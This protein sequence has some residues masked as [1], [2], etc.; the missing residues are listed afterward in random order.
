M[1]KQQKGAGPSMY[2]M[3][4][5]PYRNKAW[6]TLLVLSGILLTL[7]VAYYGKSLGLGGIGAVGLWISARVIMNCSDVKRK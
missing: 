4:Q 2:E 1:N 6:F 7:L 5:K 3:A